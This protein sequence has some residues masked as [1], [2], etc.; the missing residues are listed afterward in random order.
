MKGEITQFTIREGGYNLINNKTGKT[1]DELANMMFEHGFYS[2]RPDINTFLSDLQADIA[3][4]KPG[5]GGA[6]YPM[7]TQYGDAWHA[8][9]REA[10]DMERLLDKHGD[11]VIQTGTDEAGKAVL[12]PVRDY[13]DTAWTDESNAKAKDVLFKAAEDCFVDDGDGET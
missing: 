3:A 13:L 9:Q 2:E 5:K 1:L 12:Q 8:T 6:L 4:K 10:H 11:A 7:D